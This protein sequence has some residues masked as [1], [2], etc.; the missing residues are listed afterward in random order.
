MGYTPQFRNDPNPKL[1]VTFHDLGEE[2]TSSQPK[3]SF[4][5][6]WAQVADES[7]KQQ[8]KQPKEQQKS[9]FQ[10]LWSQV[11]SEQP[12]FLSKA[13]RIGAQYGLGILQGT[14]AGI[15]YETSV[16][17]LASKSAM[18]GAYRTQLSEDLDQ[19]MDKKALGFWSEEDEKEY[20]R[21]VD[22]IQNPEKLEQ[23][24][25]PIDITLGGLA[26][27]ATGVD[28][29]PEGIL[30][31]GARWMGW[32]K[33]SASVAQLGKAGL[34]P[35][36]VIKAII[37]TKTEALRGISAGVGL[38]MAEEN[39]F[40]PIGTMAAGIVGDLL[41]HGTA[42][43]AGGAA[44]II[45]EP[46]KYLAE[47]AAKLAP[48]EQVEL[49][50]KI[51]KDFRSA[52]LQADLG[53]ITDSNL[54][55][56]TQAKLAQSGLTGDAAKEFKQELTDQIE[57]QYKELANSL[58]NA[59]Y[60]TEYEAGS[61]AKQA[62]NDIREAD[63]KQTRSLYEESLAKLNQ[64][65]EIPYRAKLT[66]TV[67]K[68]KSK[69]KPGKIK[70]AE[71]Q[72]VLEILGKLEGDL[73]HIESRTAKPAGPTKFDITGK[74]IQ[75]EVSQPSTIKVAKNPNVLDLV[76]NKI[77]LNDII[78]YEVQ[79]GTKQLLKEVVGELDRAIISYGE[80]D[81]G[82]AKSYVNANKRFSEHSKTFRNKNISNLLRQDNPQQLMNRMN[83]L[84]GIKSLGKIFNKSPE[85][86]LIFDSLKRQK[87]DN[88]IG[89]NLVDSTSQQV[90]LGT[91]SKLLEKGNNR[92]VIKEILGP[93]AFNR[94]E[95][96]QKNAGR[97]AESAN[98]FYN[99]SQSAVAG[100]DAAV[101]YAGMNGF[102]SMLMGNP[103]PLMKTTAAVVGTRK[104]S[105]L[106]FDKEFLKLVEDAVL[107]T[108]KVSANTLP[109]DVMNKFF[110]L[111]PYFKPYVLEAKEQMNE[112]SQSL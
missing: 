94:L 90:K 104:L 41:A 61:I 59:K 106:M 9:N 37:P 39:D 103:W 69:L 26:E 51:V 32:I 5:D 93:T 99:T 43:L 102:A 112:E 44:K 91:F 95:R 38:Q 53:T 50:Q 16:A 76:N 4:H 78:N 40:G 56:M 83:N 12:G 71:Q 6:L 79:G 18:A 58:G 7:K 70:S 8:Q 67:K 64:K 15:A 3:S 22:L 36:D 85:G 42:G 84:H 75:A 19:L 55:K 21:I 98:K 110:K 45:K 11:E 72:K 29:E 81:P 20:D 57:R 47:K 88:V 62:I 30:E 25:Q 82:F 23:F 68:I 28:L 33:N 54:V 14:P 96:L 97:L 65:S 31:K 92:E 80:K 2:E 73:Y 35:N 52:G 10:D 66:D 109:P 107:A 89:K 27:K 34:K 74:P 100:A 101:I 86:R 46:K 108:D 1:R 60:A 87:L 13:G 63:L 105:N 17:P 48:K 77:A 24:A 111:F 49:Q